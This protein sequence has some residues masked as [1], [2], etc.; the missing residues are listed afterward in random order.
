MSAVPTGH[1]PAACPLEELYVLYNPSSGGADTSLAAC[2]STWAT[3][4]DSLV[5]FAVLAGSVL[6]DSL[7]DVA[8]VW[9]A[10]GSVSLSSGE[11]WAIRNRIH[12]L[13]LSNCC[14]QLGNLEW[15]TSSYTLSWKLE[16]RML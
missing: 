7:S 8:V 11:C 4:G 2:S 1:L 5:E 16:L 13:R 15:Q 10:L 14:T 9:A 6:H 3:L 12:A